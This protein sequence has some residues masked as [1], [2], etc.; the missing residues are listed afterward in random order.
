MQPDDS[1]TDVVFIVH[2]IRDQG[3]WTQ[4]L[5][6]RVKFLGAKQR[7]IAS[8]ASGY[9]Y[10]PMLPFLLPW[11][12]RSK[13]EWLIDQYTEAL[14][15]LSRSRLFLHRSQ[16]WD[17]PPRPCASGLP[18]LT[19]QPHCVRGERRAQG[20]RLVFDARNRSGPGCPQLR[21]DG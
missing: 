21:G 17:L 3:Y 9:G 5:A 19:L 7:N 18:V 8:V 2:G 10:F 15:T 14:A 12:R 11:G 16:Q 4:K 20:L 1:V 6:Q 13:V